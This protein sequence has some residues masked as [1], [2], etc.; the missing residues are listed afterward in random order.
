MIKT[1][2]KLTD[3]EID[4]LLK[5]LVVVMDTREQAGSHVAE[6]LAKKKVKMKI[7]KLDSAD[8]TCFIES[9]EDTKPLGI[10]R[11]LYIDTFIE[12]KNSIDEICGNLSKANA[13]AFENEL[14]RLQGSKFVLFVED[15]NFDENINSS[16]YRSKYTNTALKG[17][18]E[19]LKVK[20]SFEIIPM[21]RKMLPQ[22]LYYRF[23]YQARHVLKNCMY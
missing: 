22:N 16:N 8:Y 7:H 3:K 18:L 2:Y 1:K 17:R 11:D 4:L 6:Y 10:H 12:R 23:Y 14:I 19:S 15:E 20:Y 9:N 5:N 21:S 13:S